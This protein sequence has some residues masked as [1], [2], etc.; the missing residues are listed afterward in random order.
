MIG[1]NAAL[2]QFDGAAGLLFPLLARALAVTPFVPS[3]VSRLWGNAG[4][5]RS[6]LDDHRLAAGCGRAW[7]NT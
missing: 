5:V 7:R 6:L 3:V 2:G 1:I 4:K